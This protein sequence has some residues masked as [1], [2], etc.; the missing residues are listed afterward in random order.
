MKRFS[1]ARLVAAAAL[2]GLAGAAQAQAPYPSRPVTIVVPYAPGGTTDIIARMAAQ[3]LSQATGQSFVVDNRPG[4]SGTI[5]MQYVA[6][7]PADGYTLLANEI[8]QTVVPALFPNLRFDPLKDLTPVTL[9]AETPVVL[10]V[11]TKIPVRNMAELLAYGKAGNPLNF[12]SGGAGSGPH[13]AGELLKQVTGLPLT[14]VPYRGSGPAVTGLISGQI[15]LLSSAAPTI[16][17]HVVNGKIRAVA[18]AGQRRVPTVPD[19][20]TAAEAGLPAFQFSIWFGLAAPAGTPREVVQKLNTELARMVAKPEVREKLA[21]AGAEPV[22]AG[23]AD[24]GKRIESETRRW[25]DLIRKTGIKL[26]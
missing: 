13:I 16:A 11:T 22:G 18:V 19:V 26:D 4:A 17:P 21:A 9:I 7:A 3:H 12:G 20:P 5:A 6:K 15:Q 14:H 1:T 2:I 23:P 8:T 25:G 24:F 10:G